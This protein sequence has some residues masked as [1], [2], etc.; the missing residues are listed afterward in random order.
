MAKR[1]TEN[2]IL[3]RFTVTESA[4]NTY[5]QVDIPLPLAQVG[6]GKVQAFELMKIH[7]RLGDPSPEAGQDNSQTGQIVRRSET[8]PIT[9]ED[10]SLVYLRTASVHGE[11]GAAGEM[12]VTLQQDKTDDLTDGDGNG[13]ILA[14][15]TIHAGTRGSG[16]G[17][18]GYFQGWLMGHIVELDAAEVAAQ[19][20][21]DS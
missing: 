1:L 21:I 8:A 20:F 4:A 18:A 17:A 5:T 6:H 2:P 14:E 16:N 19:A 7:S 11:T 10:D 15:R 13:I 3:I 12:S 9:H